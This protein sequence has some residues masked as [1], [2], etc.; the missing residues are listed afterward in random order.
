MRQGARTE[1]EQTAVGLYRCPGQSAVSDLSVKR[2]PQ[3]REQ[4]LVAQPLFGQNQEPRRRL[5][6]PSR[7]TGAVRVPSRRPAPKQRPSAGQIA[8]REPVCAEIR[9]HARIRRR[10]Q[11]RPHAAPHRL[12]VIG[13]PVPRLAAVAPGGSVGGVE[14]DGAPRIGQRIDHRVKLRCRRRALGEAARIVGPQD[15]TLGG[16]VAGEV[17]AVAPALEIR[18]IKPARWIRGDKALGTTKIS[19]GAVG[20]AFRASLTDPGPHGGVI[21]R[22]D[23]KVRQHTV[24]RR[25]VTDQ[26]IDG[27]VRGGLKN[28]SLAGGVCG[29][30]A[31]LVLTDRQ[32]EP[33][34]GIRRCRRDGGSQ[35][36]NRIAGAAELKQREPPQMARGRVIGDDLQNGAVGHDR[37]VDLSGLVRPQPGLQ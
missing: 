10:G 19:D 29:G 12:R 1:G 28:E 17:G 18:Q 14:Q 21:R 31:Q 30:L 33:G 16:K 23:G 24:G 35:V 11:R 36:A 26:H 6:G 2:S 7:Q 37:V 15:Q 9:S 27:A 5:S 34:L 22:E 3:G 8:G 4:Q 25:R 13:H 32:M 20:R